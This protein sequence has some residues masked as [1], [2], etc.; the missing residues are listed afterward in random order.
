MTSDFFILYLRTIFLNFC[1]I[2]SKSDSF[3]VGVGCFMLFKLIESFKYIF[4]IIFSV[5][6][7]YCQAFGVSLNL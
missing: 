1:V 4:I 5:I 6:Y 7:Q 2:L 3:F